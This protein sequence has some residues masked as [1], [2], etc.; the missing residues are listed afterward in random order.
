MNE[1]VIPIE[2]ETPDIESYAH[3]IFRHRLDGLGTFIGEVL[4]SMGLFEQEYIYKTNK[5]IRVKPQLFLN[6]MPEEQ[7]Q[8][9]ISLRNEHGRTDEIMQQT[10]WFH[11]NPVPSPEIIWHPR[12]ERKN[13][14]GD[15]LRSLFHAALTQLVSAYEI[16]IGDTARAILRD[17]KELLAV[18]ERQLTSKEIIDLQDYEKLIDVLIERAVSKLTHNVTY[19]KLVNRFHI[20]YHI[21]IHNRNSPVQLF[22]VHHLIEKRNIIVHNDGVA[23]SKYIEKLSSYSSPELLDENEELLV[24]FLRFYND[25]LMIMELGKYI[26]TC[27]QKKWPSLPY[28]TYRINAG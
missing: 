19:P 17:E 18:D 25:L 11:E 12:K 5:E 21:G 24:D 23:S 15:L 10:S 1:I 6:D 28:M 7:R 16:F 27:T 2:S 9:L 22:Q 4:L 8:Q 26:E 20:K 13:L 14:C 3:Y